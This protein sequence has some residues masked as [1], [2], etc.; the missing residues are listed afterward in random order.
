ME[1]MQSQYVSK[2]SFLHNFLARPQQFWMQYG[3]LDEQI[4]K[5][6]HNSQRQSLSKL[7]TFKTIEI[8]S[9]RILL[10]LEWYLVTLSAILKYN[11][12]GANYLWKDGK[13]TWIFKLYFFTLFWWHK[14]AC[15]IIRKLFRLYILYLYNWKK[16]INCVYW[17]RPQ[18]I[19]YTY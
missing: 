6:T 8:C 11:F 2:V 13:Y 1:A 18:Y 16:R 3:I 7:E 14:F 19:F 10:S 4:L 9:N 17:L 12:A 15:Y 5:W